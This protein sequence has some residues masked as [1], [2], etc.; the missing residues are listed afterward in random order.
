MGDGG[1]GSGWGWV[2]TDLF[3]RR[4]GRFVA[5]QGG[6]TGRPAPVG[7]ALRVGPGARL[8]GPYERLPADGVARDESGVVPVAQGVEDGGMDRRGVRRGQ[9][10]GGGHHSSGVALSCS[11]AARTTSSGGTGA[12]SGWRSAHFA[13][14]EQ[15]GTTGTP[16]RAAI[17]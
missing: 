6:A 5:S 9:G 2:I 13:A 15:R 4:V 10:T 8:P 17:A 1:S 14:Y 12:S 11:F 16:S 3:A 7:P